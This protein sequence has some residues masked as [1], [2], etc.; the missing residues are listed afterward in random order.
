[1]VATVTRW[2]PCR[3]ATKHLLWLTVPA[4]LMASLLSD[5]QCDRQACI[6]V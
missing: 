1:M 3:P 5:G 2:L 6:I 4:W